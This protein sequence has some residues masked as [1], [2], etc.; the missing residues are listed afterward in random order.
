MDLQQSKEKLQRKVMD[1]LQ[2]R[3]KLLKENYELKQKI[4]ELEKRNSAIQDAL[5]ASMNQAPE[6][7]GEVKCIEMVTL[8]NESQHELIF[9]FSI[10]GDCMETRFSLM[11]RN[12]RFWIKLMMT[13][14]I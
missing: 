7:G 3:E 4:I 5:V 12:L 9:V 11:H 8:G 10:V 14:N 13:R 6:T 2:V 1:L